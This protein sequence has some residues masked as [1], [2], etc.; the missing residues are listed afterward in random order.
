MIDHTPAPGSR[1]A[2]KT[3][4]VSGMGTALEF[5]DFVIYGYAAALVFPQLFFPG[6]DRLT[7]VL[8]A[9]AAFGAGFLARPLGGVVFGHLGDRYG[10]QK[11]L[12]ATLLLM[13]A[14]T[15]LIGFLPDY[16]SLGVAAPALLVALR[17]VQGFAAGGEWGGAALFG[18]EVAPCGRRGL[19]G[20]FTSMGIGIGGI[21][22]SAV[23]A[24]VSLAYNDDLSGVAWRIPF[25][26]G[27][28]L[29]LIGL[30]ARLQNGA[31]A[32]Q[33]KPQQ[34][35]RL[36][37]LDA[38][39]QR[40]R[41]LLLCS[42]IAFGYITVAYIS[43]FFLAYATDIGYSSSQALLF[44]FALSIAIVLSAPFF[45][46]L[47]DRYGRRT[48]MIFGAAI[49]ALGLFAFFPLLGTHQ[50][51]LALLGYLAVGF[52]M[53]ATQGP[54]PAFLAEQF[55]RSMRYSGISASYQLGA[56]LGG[57]TASS[58]ATAILIASGHQPVYVALYGAAAMALV[59]ICSLLLRETAHLEMAALDA[60]AAAPTQAARA[61]P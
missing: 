48:V 8:V 20:S 7:A 36:P 22:G 27:G 19:W 49:M 5:Y 43:T 4:C 18:I 21:F 38:L 54:I 61:T 15:L 50:L 3:F 37:L 41:E 34:R 29:V 16:H 42:G 33:P 47:S 59:A 13:G 57:G 12:V 32:E 14:S 11:A 26:L 10:R 52:F 56:A 6:L 58:A 24:L 51:G 45:G 2:F 46:H 53:G 23:F 31:P 55:P 28:V 44:D 60:D 17:L 39:R 35:A 1:S 40:P 25:W 9:F 30:Y